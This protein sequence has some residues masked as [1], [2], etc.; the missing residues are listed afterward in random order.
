MYFTRFLRSQQQSLAHLVDHYAQYPPTGLTMKRIVEFAREGDAQQSFLFLRNELPVRLASM[1]KEM[2]HLPP[3]LLQMP[4][5]KTVN[6]WY[7]TS[8]TELHTFKGAQP[9]K[10]VVRKFT[11]VLQNIRKRHSSVIETLAEG[12]MEFSDL[13]QV[14]EYE[15]SQIQY[16]LNRFYLSRISIRLLIYQHTMCFGDEVAVHPTH[17]GFVDPNCYVEDTIKEAFENA[18]FLCESY[19]LTAPA[20]EL[21]SINAINPNEPIEIAYVPSHLY[22]VMFELFKNAMRATVEYA[23]SK[24][25]NEPLPPIIVDIVK[26]KEDLTIRISDRGGGVPRSRADKIFRYMYSTAPRPVSPADAQHSGPVPLAGFGYG[27]PIVCKRN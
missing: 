5:V 19:Y 21:R 16:F 9:T 24:K 13:G 15:E 7:G 12:Y 6:G 20:L 4:S 25:S 10:E 22:H 26:A 8:L 17:L 14:K 1:M 2:G 27:L 3:R 23:E 11:E 18:Q